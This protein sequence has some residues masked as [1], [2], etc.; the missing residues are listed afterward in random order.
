MTGRADPNCTGGGCLRPARRPRLL[1]L[2]LGLGLSVVAAAADF[3]VTEA[4]TRLLNDVYHL[5]ARIEYH[6][7]SAALEALANGVP[8]TLDVHIQVRPATAWVWETSLVDQRLR[9]RIRY[10]PL[11]ERYLVAR[12]PGE[13]GRTFV[14]R[15]A[16]LAALGD[17][18]GLQ[19]VGAGRLDPERDYEVHIRTALDIEE[20]PL[21]LR[22]RAY[23]SRAWR[24]TSSWTK[25]P[26]TP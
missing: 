6:F 23:L 9:Y 16:A 25:W 3:R 10:K 4:R 1:A 7:S 2:L 19:L 20:L 24:Q 5:D 12:L 13:T 21:P 26:L 11:S 15:E 22:P 18:R 17:L 8:L 14:S